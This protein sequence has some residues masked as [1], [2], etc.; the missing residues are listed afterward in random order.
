MINLKEK[1]VRG[2]GKNKAKNITGNLQ[3]TYLDSLDNR[4][5]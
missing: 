3:L 1:T 2:K 5:M 4:S